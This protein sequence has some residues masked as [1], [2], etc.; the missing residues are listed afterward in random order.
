MSFLLMILAVVSAEM[1]SIVGRGS[2]FLF[3][4]S[5][6]DTEAELAWLPN[7]DI[8]RSW[9]VRP[10]GYGKWGY[11][12]NVPP[13][14]PPYQKT[15][16]PADVFDGDAASGY[17]W[18]TVSLNGEDC[19]ADST[20]CQIL[21]IDGNTIAAYNQGAGG[22]VCHGCHG[23]SGC[24]DEAMTAH[25]MCSTA[26]C[27][28]CE[29]LN[30][31]MAFDTESPALIKSVGITIQNERR[32]PR[33][34]KVYYSPESIVGPFYE[35]AT[36]TMTS[37]VPGKVSFEA[38]DHQAKIARFWKIE[39]ES[40]WGDPDHV[41]LLEFEFFG[42]ILTE[43]IPAKWVEADTNCDGA[44]LSTATLDFGFASALSNARQL[45]I[46]EFKLKVDQ[47]ELGPYRIGVSAEALRKD[48]LA[49]G[50]TTT[51]TKYSLVEGKKHGK[52]FF[53]SFFQPVQVSLMVRDLSTMITGLNLFPDDVYTLFKFTAAD[54]PK[55]YCVDKNQAVV[56][57]TFAA[58][59]ESKR[60]SLCLNG[61]MTSA[62]ETVYGITGVT[63]V[64]GPVG[65]LVSLQMVGNVEGEA[66]VTMVDSSV[67]DSLDCEMA[68]SV[69]SEASFPVAE[70][71][72]RVTLSAAQ[73]VSGARFCVRYSGDKTVIAP[74]INFD[75][76]EASVTGVMGDACSNVM[77]GTTEI[78][79][80]ASGLSVDDTVLFATGGCE[81]NG[82]VGGTGIVREVTAE[83][84]KVATAFTS[85]GTY[86]VVATF[87]GVCHSFPEA[88][89]TIFD[90]HATEHFLFERVPMTLEVT[91]P[92]VALPESLEFRK[93]DAALNVQASI[94]Q[95]KAGRIVF[96][97]LVNDDAAEG[98]YTLYFKLPGCAAMLPLPE[99]FSFHHIASMTTLIGE[100]EIPFVTAVLN[101][102]SP[103]ILRGL[104]LKES[105]RAYFMNAEGDKVE[106]AMASVTATEVRGTVTFAKN[107]VYG[108]YYVFH[109]TADVA[110]GFSVSISTI[111]KLILPLSDAEQEPMVVKDMLTIVGYSGRGIHDVNREA[112]Y[113]ALTPNPALTGG[114]GAEDAKF[115]NH[116]AVASHGPY[117]TVDDM[118]S[119]MDA[120]FAFDNGGRSTELNH[121][122]VY[123][124]KNV[125]TIHKFGMYI[126]SVFFQQLPRDYELQALLNCYDDDCV[127]GKK[128]PKEEAPW[129]T[130][131]SVR[132]LRKS[133]SLA[134]EFE[135][136]DLDY[137]ATA[138]YFRLLITKNWG[139]TVFTSVIQVD[140]IGAKA[141]A[142]DMNGA[143]WVDTGA[144]CNPDEYWAV[145]SIGHATINTFTSSG[146]KDLCY[147]F[148]S[149]ASAVEALKISDMHLRVAEVTELSPRTV[150]SH[151]SIPMSVSA[152]YG[153]TGDRV[154]FARP[155]ATKDSDCWEATSRAFGSVQDKQSI[156]FTFDKVT[157][158][159]SFI[160]SANGEKTV[161]IFID[162]T[163]AEVAIKL[164]QLSG[165]DKAE[166][167]VHHGGAYTVTFTVTVIE[168]AG[169][170]PD[171]EV[172][173]PSEEG[174]EKCTSVEV[175]KNE[176][177]VYDS[178]N[179]IL[180]IADPESACTFSSFNLNRE[181][182]FATESAT[183]SFIPTAFI[184]NQ[185]GKAKS[186]VATAVSHS[187]YDFVALGVTSCPASD[188]C[189]AFAA[190]LLSAPLVDHL[191]VGNDASGVVTMGED[192]LT[193]AIVFKY[194]SSYSNLGAP[195]CYKFGN[196]AWKIYPEITI[197]LYSVVDV[198]PRLF[199]AGETRTATVSGTE[200]SI[201]P[202]DFFRVLMSGDDCE[203][204]PFAQ[205]LVNGASV[206]TLEV[207]ANNQ[208]D[209]TF[210]PET[211]L[212][213][214][215]TL[216][217]RFV[218]SNV[219]VH[220]TNI[221]FTVMSV[222]T[223]TATVPTMAGD[224]AVAEQSKWFNFNGNSLS[225]NDMMFFVRSSDL[226]VPEARMNV[227]VSGSDK[228]LES[229]NVLKVRLTFEEPATGLVL[230]YH[231]G[232]S[233]DESYYMRY[234]NINMSVLKITGVTPAYGYLNEPAANYVMNGQWPADYA[235]VDTATW[236]LESDESVTMTV[237]VYRFNQQSNCDVQLSTHGRFYL[238]YRFGKEMPVV[239]RD[240]TIY[241]LGLSG[242]QN[243]Y[244]IVG[245]MYKPVFDIDFY[246]HLGETSEASL[247][248][249]SF[250]T[251]EGSCFNADDF[252][253]I[254]TATG[255]AL[256]RAP[257]YGI[258]ES[259]AYAQFVVEKTEGGEYDVCYHWDNA[260][261]VNYPNLRAFFYQ[262]SSFTS[263]E[264][265]SNMLV[266]GVEKKLNVLGQG[267]GEGDE[268]R[269]ISPQNVNPS[270]CT[271]EPNTGDDE[272]NAPYE[273]KTF[274]VDASN[275]VTMKVDEMPAG[276]LQ[277][278]YKF[279]QMDY[280]V[281]VP[282]FVTVAGIRKVAA[283]VGAPNVMVVDQEK[284]FTFSGT[285]IKAGD[286]V[287]WGER[288][289]GEESYASAEQT[290]DE[291]LTA[292]FVFR[293]KVSR[294]FVLCYKHSN[295]GYVAYPAFTMS[296]RYIESMVSADASA[297][298]DLSI[299]HLE[300]TVKFSGQGI[301]VDTPDVARWVKGDSCETNTVM[302]VNEQ[303]AVD[304]S[305]IE[306]SAE[307][308]SRPQIKSKSER[309]GKAMQA[310]SAKKN[311]FLVH[312]DGTASFAFA[313]DSSAQSDERFYLCYK[314]GSEPFHLYRDIVMQVFDLYDVASYSQ[315]DKSDN[316]YQVAS[317]DMVSVEFTGYGVSVGDR[318]YWVGAE[319]P[320]RAA[321]ALPIESDHMYEEN[322]VSIDSRHKSSINFLFG[323]ELPVFL[324][325][326]FG[327]EPVNRYPYNFRVSRVNAVR[328]V[329]GTNA[330]VTHVPVEMNFYGFNININSPVND[331]FAWTRQDCERGL[332][333]MTDASAGETTVSALGEDG[334]G[335][336]TF[337]EGGEFSL[338][339][340]FGNEKAVHYPDV[341]ISLRSVDEIIPW[342]TREEVAA[343]YSMDRVAV[344]KYMKR[345]A[346]RGVFEHG[347]LL[348]FAMDGD[349]SS[350]LARVE[351]PTSEQ[352]R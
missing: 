49:A 89:V 284:A 46:G 105:D 212:S 314:F 236:V 84:V 240:I 187:L 13:Y 33:T 185:E 11:S 87:S 257:V 315:E 228:I 302:M 118:D 279:K 193:T 166:V 202:G 251:V 170:Q 290:V 146:M 50:Y 59:P 96:D 148:S 276:E 347:D 106:V 189:E 195:L 287:Y 206:T 173:L 125:T 169:A 126:N 153:N 196:S 15:G 123:D 323:Y 22:R 12:A 335:R 138:R 93:E 150:A 297:H 188:R 141:S 5:D 288:C 109:N 110:F 94:K 283:D 259:E 214:S 144:A 222:A 39:I 303:S 223:V 176:R 8:R 175:C 160:L 48:L 19:P 200:D 221:H 107:G 229:H 51:V 180:Q 76:E 32:S 235:E 237:P 154:K 338:C 6:C 241:G 312:V 220:Y 340:F 351:V 291:S 143:Q 227:M 293:E 265:D 306:P 95:V 132:D 156:A 101:K 325:Y 211:P 191:E 199:I 38:A 299:V 155:G 329:D 252:L 337:N 213:A 163:G 117:V 142:N 174:C 304:M 247:D 133:T 44:A 348:S 35:F 249:V 318:A 79:L 296:V 258:S 58:I 119:P 157:H 121:W 225:Q 336:V 309:L 181:Y 307:G 17:V 224:L 272:C 343:G 31:V 246:R 311:S 282:V 21:T 248:T 201:N 69:L 333:S 331:R 134:G 74:S 120:N 47:T 289:D 274:A 209:I 322:V 164:E 295:E 99:V 250:K 238:S 90:Y 53:V 308:E 208:L 292:H 268:V 273:G 42:Q 319:Y 262:L 102:E 352:E 81:E 104:S 162:D 186:I 41:E 334:K 34:I 7:D 243:T 182:Q 139:N 204:G 280:F 327:N 203:N 111:E 277:V 65:G 56:L 36:Y 20:N 4:D 27:D 137:D 147:D 310:A 18:K 275:S 264:G 82:V 115:Y 23:V 232:N 75:I 130:V 55:A 112:A 305:D 124:L 350:N 37:L 244:G 267:I 1:N 210:D 245:C 171:F 233:E 25:P 83:G 344:K 103:V 192:A 60:A 301:S 346:V 40:N 66:S 345:W 14:S 122:I 57:S 91:G 281:K 183:V 2:S 78:T 97:V 328:N 320:C 217:Y 230:C 92:Q 254:E 26:V 178:E 98:E 349:C 234:D 215:W 129:V 286:K 270:M 88:T 216:C 135:Y 330:F 16:H 266:I 86:H 108:L 261:T 67:S 71:A 167:S 10:T 70:M 131:L 316:K 177:F 100:S 190:T 77:M 145:Q 28:Y 61:M 62:K 43:A 161:P 317:G 326:Q 151:V 294:Q 269:L 80:A 341:T 300:K 271:V 324:C 197:D 114:D 136:A 285:G 207:G 278:C 339:H 298:D 218:N 63:P 45:E 113:H 158:K 73:P 128:A 159:G 342:W 68:Q 231:F 313:E 219:Y 242:I 127:F 64:Y 54:A 85:Y 3:E 205:L 179:R 52:A 29:N 260:K 198:Q 332:V 24:S 321:N 255:S 30:A 256:Q 239:Y 149:P 9:G 165:I 140:F 194:E 152:V 184:F 226:C 253:K 116:R 168:P 172:I 72:A 263:S